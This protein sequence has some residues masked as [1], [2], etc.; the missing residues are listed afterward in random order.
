MW[1]SISTGTAAALWFAAAGTAFAEDVT[2]T[3]YY[4][5]PRGAYK[6]LRVTDN[7]ATPAVTITQTGAGA[8]ISITQASAG[9]ALVVTQT[10]AGPILRVNDAAGDTTPFVI[11]AAGDVGIGIAN[12]G[13]NLEILGSNPVVGTLGFGDI[14]GDMWYDGGSDSFFPFVHKGAAA[15]STA[16]CYQNSATR[17]LTIRN[18]GNT[19]AGP[20]TDPANIPALTV[21][22][23]LSV[24]DVAG[25][26]GNLDANDVHVRDA[27]GGNAKWL[28][29]TITRVGVIVHGNAP[30]GNDAGACNVLP[31]GA[32]VWEPDPVPTAG[33]GLLAAAVGAIPSTT[34]H[35][36]IC[37]SRK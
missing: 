37:V 7:S 13:S 18:D 25:Q 34:Q 32:A 28:S 6:E 19:I 35:A 23:K 8:G 33:G 12:P 1:R 36:H 15:G 9:T 10:G 3:T 11:D 4:P 21:S 27:G 5:S 31:G 26:R 30:L 2:L 24:A 14:N 17:L 16:F 22:G 20:T 29:G